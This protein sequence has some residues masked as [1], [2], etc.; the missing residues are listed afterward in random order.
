MLAG[1][2]PRTPPGTI[3]RQGHRPANAQGR[4]G[5]A[6]FGS[7]V[8]LLVDSLAQVDLIEQRSTMDIGNIRFAIATAALISSSAVAEPLQPSGKWV[9][10]YAEAQCVAERSFG[11][12]EN[13]VHLTIKPSPTSDIVQVGLIRNG[14]FSYGEQNKARIK[15]GSFPGKV[16]NVLEFGTNQGKKVTY[17]NLPQDW[18]AQLS[19]SQSIEWHIKDNVTELSTGPMAEVMKVM[20]NCRSDLRNY[21]NIGPAKSDALW[22]EAEPVRPL[23]TYFN[24][25]DYPAQALDQGE[26]G[27]TSVVLLVDEKG[28]IQDCMIDGTS[29]IATIDAMT[30]IV[31]RKRAKFEP[32]VDREGKPAKGAFMQKVRWELAN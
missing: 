5:D 12:G 16:T 3:G 6:R 32:A 19:Q 22:A 10:N 24:S 27:T 13:A 31:I 14:K 25:E 18:A 9:I 21:W 7:K 1:P 2:P 8:R 29:G 17:A 28:V 20:A 30:C 15:I 26:D 11:T 23:V 4:Y